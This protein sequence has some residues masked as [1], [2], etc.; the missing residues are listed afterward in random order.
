MQVIE[1]E[2]NGVCH[3]IVLPKN[4]SYLGQEYAAE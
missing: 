1:T 2:E 4:P 3:P